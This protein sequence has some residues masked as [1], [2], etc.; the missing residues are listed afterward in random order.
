[1]EVMGQDPMTEDNST[2]TLNLELAPII[3]LTEVITPEVSRTNHMAMTVTETRCLVQGDMEVL[4][5]TCSTMASTMAI[6]PMSP[7]LPNHSPHTALIPSSH[8]SQ[9]HLDQ[10]RIPQPEQI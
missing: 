2:G 8:T 4:P 9:S 10:A 7:L 5:H 1:M 3:I 6:L